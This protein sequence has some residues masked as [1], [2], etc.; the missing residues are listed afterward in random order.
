M[1]SAATAAA[2]DRFFIVYIPGTY[3]LGQ[4]QERDFVSFLLAR[5]MSV[6]ETGAYNCFSS[7]FDIGR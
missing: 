1:K 2:A 7:R 4:E 6:V 5:K 3:S